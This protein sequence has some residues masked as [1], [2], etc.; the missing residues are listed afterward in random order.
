M[1]KGGASLAPL[2]TGVKGGV[3]ADAQSLVEK[4]EKEIKDGIF[5]VNIDEAQPAGSVIAAKD[6]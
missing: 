3:P 5:R 2:N 6:S 1:G 4:R